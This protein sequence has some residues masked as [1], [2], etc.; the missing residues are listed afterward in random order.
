MV[1]FILI[2]MELKCKKEVMLEI[3]FK[4]KYIQLEEQLVLKTIKRKLQYIMIDQ[5]VELH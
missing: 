4:I 3:Q 2:Q 1:N 5:K